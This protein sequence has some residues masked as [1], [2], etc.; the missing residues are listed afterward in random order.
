MLTFHFAFGFL[1][2][3][4]KI[5]L[6]ALLDFGLPFSCVGCGGLSAFLSRLGFFFQSLLVS[7]AL[8]LSNGLNSCA[9][10]GL[11]PAD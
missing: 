7:L 11:L 5:L 2:L 3:I 1:H 4:F 10:L 6:V 8:G 9:L